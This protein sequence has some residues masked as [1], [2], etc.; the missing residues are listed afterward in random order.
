LSVASA[1]AEQ[2]GAFASL[3]GDVAL[4]QSTQW[5]SVRALPG[6]DVPAVRAALTAA[7]LKGFVIDV[8]TETDQLFL[9]RLNAVHADLPA[10]LRR[11]ESS[12]AVRWAMAA[13]H[14]PDGGALGL[15]EGVL[16]L[17][18]ADMHV[19][20]AKIGARV[21]APIPFSQGALLELTA[22]TAA[23][24]L[25]ACTALRATAGVVEAHPNFIRRI[26][27]RK[28]LNDPYLSNQWYLNPIEAQKA[29]DTTTGTA[30]VIVAVIDDGFDMEHE[31]YA[32]KIVD[33]AY[34]FGGNDEW[35]EGQWWDN[36]GTAVSGIA[37]ATG[38][39]GKGISGVCPACSFMPIRQ[40]NTDWAI[41]NSFEHVGQHGAHVV[42]NS[43]GFNYPSQSIQNAITGVTTQGRDGKGTMVIF[44]SGNNGQN[45]DQVQDISTTP[46]AVAVSSANQWDT[47][48]GYS[49]WGKSIDIGAPADGQY[50]TDKTQGGYSNGK[51]T[52]SF[53]GTSGA[54]PVVAGAAGLIFSLDPAMTEATARNLMFQGADKVGGGYGA[55]GK[56]KDFGHGRLN[57][58]KAVAL[59]DGEAIVDPDPL[60]EPDPGEGPGQDP[61]PADGASCAN[62]CGGEAPSGCWCDDQCAGY[63][64]CCADAC[65]Q[66]GEDC[67]DPQQP[68]EPPAQ[69]ETCSEFFACA[70]SCQ[71]QSCMQSCQEKTDPAELQKAQA[72]IN[73]L[74]SNGCYNVQTQAQL[75]ECAEQNCASDMETCFQPEVVEPEP[76]PD[77]EP[78]P[79]VEPDV[80]TDPGGETPPEDDPAGEP[81]V[82]PDEPVG[83]PFPIDDGEVVSEGAGGPGAGEHIQLSKKMRTVRNSCSA[84]AGGS[85]GPGVALLLLTLA[86]ATLVRRRLGTIP[87]SR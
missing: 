57:V 72:L 32:S 87:P 53:G 21:V 29:W 39:N 82:E 59:Y 56:S 10:T 2:A 80:P 51:Y 23:D 8:Q 50:T 84:A 3:Q 28:Q 30:Q 61:P 70:Q 7:G 9:V 22:P 62:F 38:N 65:D 42:N 18:S 6:V 86:I 35:P 75:Q 4:T 15:T 83:E 24:V 44:A 63:G 78:D 5:I 34:D 52:G 69:D 16:V 13:V 74:Q 12:Q 85:E 46:G 68:V 47:K 40:G 31:D 64:D 67:K 77:P 37:I 19:L 76:M 1:S 25:S 54:A 14:T 48:A 55:D 36:H 49:N 33:G 73:C 20:A 27:K 81:D 26:D 60:P 41:I 79:G 11:V 66:C 45:I 58:A 43:W 17:G 71:T